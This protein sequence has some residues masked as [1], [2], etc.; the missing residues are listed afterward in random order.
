MSDSKKPF[1]P[2]AKLSDDELADLMQRGLINT[3]ILQEQKLRAIAAIIP[4]CDRQA[5]MGLFCPFE[6]AV[7]K[8]RSWSGISYSEVV[9][10]L[11]HAI[12][13]E[14]SRAA[15][16][17]GYR[18]TLPAGGAFVLR[19]AI[20]KSQQVTGRDAEDKTAWTV[21]IEM[22]EYLK[23]Y[24]Q[25]KGIELTDEL[26]R[27]KFNVS[28]RKL[29]AQHDLAQLLGSNDPTDWKR[30]LQAEMV[31]KR[32]K[33]RGDGREID[34]ICMS[35]YKLSKRRQMM[36]HEMWCQ[37]ERRR[38]GRGNPNELFE[39]RPGEYQWGDG[40]P[41]E[42]VEVDAFESRQ[43][44]TRVVTKRTTNQRFC[45]Y[46]NALRG[47][48]RKR[49]HTPAQNVLFYLLEERT[50]K[51]PRLDA[52]LHDITMEA[53]PVYEQVKVGTRK[54]PRRKPDFRFLSR[55][56]DIE[57]LQ[58]LAREAFEDDEAV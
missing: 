11:A 25:K 44:D 4:E 12:A 14:N 10:A 36:P 51:N 37:E 41:V 38:A 35:Y 5:V 26:A 13:L 42:W 58:R 39:I 6:D 34:A 29:K 23:A 28:L 54:E 57:E 16:L 17:D 33:K 24:C 22:L 9:E 45:R 7:T 15:E 48:C 49:G 19:A 52:L 1:G 43:V 53:E 18:I 46:M 21:A 20:K 40:C 2:Y 31:A 50:K 56:T 27:E 32:A 47:W 8:M 30:L 3:D 55:S